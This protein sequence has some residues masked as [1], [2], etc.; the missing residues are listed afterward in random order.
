[1]RELRCLFSLLLGAGLLLPSG[2]GDG[3]AALLDPVDRED[4][5]STD[6]SGDGDID[7]DADGDAD[8][9]TGPCADIGEDSGEFDG[10]YQ[11]AIISVEDSD[12]TYVLQTNWWGLFGGQTVSYDGLS[13]E[14]G[15][16]DNVAMNPNEGAPTGY[17]SFLVGRYAGSQSAESNL[18]MRVSDISA[19]ETSF[20]T[21]ASDISLSNTNAAY[22]VWLTAGGAPLPDNQYDPGDGGVFLM[23]WLFMPTDRQPRGT[24]D[25]P[26]HAVDGVEGTWDVWIDE[27]GDF[28]PCISYVSTT[29]LDGLDFDLNDF[30]QDAVENDYGVTADMYLN[31]I[32]AGFELWGGNDGL[33]VEHFCADVR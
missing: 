18:P 28:P 4:D 10:Q 29:P 17:P 23:V 7:G 12:K 19:V 13:F 15:N 33:A 32:F 9:A 21:N 3:E 1:M 14:I 5:S 6:G 8:V 2:C 24:N 26:D 27:S 11:S 25:H 31:I 16:P 22:D 20:H 30:I